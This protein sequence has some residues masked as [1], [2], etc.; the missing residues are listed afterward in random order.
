VNQ[1]GLLQALMNV[2][3]PQPGAD[4]VAVGPDFVIPVYDSTAVR[5][6]LLKW[7][8]YIFTDES[9][10]KEAAMRIATQAARWGIV[11]EGLRIIRG[12]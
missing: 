12:K 8:R 6:S 1:S 11:T 4:A 9:A 5:I 10:R 3:Q 2:P 7:P